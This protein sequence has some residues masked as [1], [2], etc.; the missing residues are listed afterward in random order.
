[1]ATVFSF[2][3]KLFA[4]PVYHA[5]PPE[6]LNYGIQQQQILQQQQADLQRQQ[7]ELTE[8]QR[9]EALALAAWIP[10]D[11]WR[12]IDG[13]TNWAKAPGWMQFA[14]K[15]VEVQPKGIRIHGIYG[16]PGTVV[17]DPKDYDI[18]KD[19]FVRGFPY[20][21][22][23]NDFI[24]SVMHL[25]G[26]LNGTYTYPTVTGGSATLH[27]LL[28]GE[29]CSAPQ[30]S[31]EQIKAIQDAHKAK[32]DAAKKAK[33][34]ADTRTLKWNQDQAEQGDSYGLLRMGERYRDGDGVGK[35]ESKAR[36]NLTRSAALGNNTARDELSNLSL[37]V[38]TNVPT[39][40]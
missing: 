22:A 12:V 40:K 21:V 18:N 23:E 38:T 7:K 5:A 15:V 8:I 33:Q 2:V 35:D 28:Y 6:Q 14:G 32:A 13:K 19:F 26:M 4:G 3:F 34:D 1:M 36:E 30:P 29:P 11:P 39:A 27:E 16:E 9:Q 31:P 37:N 10:D 25:T 24:G 20:S 17:Y